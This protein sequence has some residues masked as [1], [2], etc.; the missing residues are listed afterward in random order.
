M[1]GTKGKDN[2]EDLLIGD[3]VADTIPVLNHLQTIMD[4]ALEAL[5]PENSKQKGGLIPFSA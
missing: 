5:G 2:G 3:P 1:C 4:I